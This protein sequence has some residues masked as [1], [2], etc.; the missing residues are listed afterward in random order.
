MS[1]SKTFKDENVYWR[2]TSG[3]APTSS[4]VNEGFACDVAIVGG[5]FTGLRAAIELAEAG[6]DVAVY[7]GGELGEGASG[8]SGGQVNPMLTIGKPVD[9]MRAIGRG[10]FERLAET[11]LNSA[12][13]LF[14]TLK[15][16]DIKCHQRQKGWVRANHSAVAGK[17]ARLNAKAWNRF[18]AGLEV[19][20]SGADVA[21]MT[22]AQGY[23]SAVHCLS[24]GAIHPLRLVYGL[25]DVAMAKGAK[26][27]TKAK[28]SSL[29]SRN[30]Q[31]T[32]TVNGHKIRAKFVVLA[33][34]AYADNLLTGLKRS[35]LPLTPI[36]MAT[37]K[38]TEQQ[39]KGIL[40]RNHTIS[41]TRRLIMYARRE[42][43][44]RIV[45]GGMGY[46]TPWGTVGGFQWMQ[47]DV[48]RIFPSLK[49]ANWQFKWGGRIAVTDDRLP[50]L[51]EAG[52]GVIAGLGY[53]GRGVAM[54]MVMGRVLA[55]RVLGAKPL[56]LPF[57]ITM[58]KPITFQ[59]TQMLGSAVAMG[60]M[61][62]K[63]MQE[64]K[65]GA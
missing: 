21:E 24:G 3:R 32:L 20:G 28:V 45:F 31:S 34:N 63:D 49:L 61:P 33:T 19:L 39:I 37:G 55:Q 8:R 59:R 35:F 1:V 2:D 42:P 6:V 50:H 30:D 62:F 26:I 40:P 15:K 11:A 41:D 16:Y 4:L 5:G 10:Y 9:V 14:G 57:P 60:W 58:V 36:Q 7:E 52:N 18:G 23:H 27:F 54:S 12:D 43:N 51:H 17:E 44:N 47:Q 29:E 53:N 22:G 25:A 64:M 46:R 13:E 48:A 38:L 56:D 65:K